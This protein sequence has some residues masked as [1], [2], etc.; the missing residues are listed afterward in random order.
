MTDS[1]LKKALERR[2]RETSVGTFTPHDL[3]R[4]WISHLLERG[5]D[6]ATVQKLAG[7]ASVT[8]TARYDRR[9]D[10]VKKRTAELLHVPFSAKR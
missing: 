5:G 3:R 8:T 6:I 7:H 4:S 10:H 9:G 1:A 2:R